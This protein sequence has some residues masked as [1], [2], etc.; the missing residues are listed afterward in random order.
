M[1]QTSAAFMSK[2]RPRAVA[3]WLL[4]VAGMIVGIVVVGGITRLTESGLSI[5][6]WKPLSGILPPLNDAQW[7]AELANY[8]TIDQSR[9]VH[10][11][12]ALAEFKGLFFWEYIHRMIG[13]TIGLAFALPLIWFALHRRIPK[14]YGWRLVAL[15]A[16]GALQGALGW[17]MVR[18]GLRPGQV[19]VGHGWLAAHLLTAMFT[20]A[21]MV[22]TALDLLDLARNPYARPAR[23]RRVSAVVGIVLFTQLMYGAFTAG[24]R[25]GKATP[26]W[27]LMYGRFFP[28]PGQTGRSFLDAVVDDPLIVQF[29]HRW[30][31]FAA[32]ALMW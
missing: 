23:L 15:L 17:L 18:S 6:T 4:F 21:G 7:Q 22:W 19:E 16:L 25:A 32:A 29:I 3:I 9:T 27:P 14:G 30:F 31:A 13:R 24:L 2:A 28:G 10:A 12:I 1:L 11:G 26:E 5:T 8:R 20:L